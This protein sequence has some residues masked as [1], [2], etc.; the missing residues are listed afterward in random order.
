MSILDTI[1]DILF[2]IHGVLFD[3]KEVKRS[4][5]LLPAHIK[6]QFEEWGASDTE[7]RKKAR[8]FY[9]DNFA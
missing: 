1:S 7:T 8:E 4:Y 9:L 6:S 5:D 3:E 2:D